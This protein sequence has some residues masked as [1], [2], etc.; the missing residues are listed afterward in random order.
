MGDIWNFA[1][2]LL[3]G[4][5]VWID[6]LGAPHVNPRSGP[7]AGV[8]PTML[9][10]G[11]FVVVVLAFVQIGRAALDGG[12]GFATLLVGIARCAVIS[13]GGLGFHLYH[14]MLSTGMR[15]AEAIGLRWVDVDLEGAYLSVVQQN[16]K[17][18]V[19]GVVG[20]PKTKR[21]TRDI[22]VGRKTVSILQRQQET[23]DLER[24]ASGPA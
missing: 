4:A 6:K 16:T 8:L 1:T 22:P 21:S 2:S 7:L 24:S 15:R 13:T 18:H 3:A 12:K 10:L 9:W 23:R 14:L 19:R 17:V 5:F 11:A 20:T